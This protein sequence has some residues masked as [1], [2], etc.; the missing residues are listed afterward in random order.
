M[1]TSS[2]PGFYKLSPTERLKKVAE[3]SGLSEEEISLLSDCGA[4]DPVR[5]DI[6]IENVIGIVGIPLGVAT[7]FKINGND[8]LIPMATEESS[9][10]AAASNAAKMARLKG[11]F[12]TEST[13]PVMIGQIQLVDVPEPNAAKDKILAAKERLLETAKEQDSILVK[14][15]GGPRDLTVKILDTEQGAMLRVHLMVDVRDAMGA[16]AVNTMAEAISPILEELSGGRALLKI[17]SNLAVHRM[18]KAKAVFAKE[19]LGG[20]DVVNNILKAY[21]FA[22]NDIYRCATHNKG[23]MNGIIAAALATGQDHRAIEAGAHVYASLESYKSLTKYSKNGDGDLVGEI[24]LPMAVAT[25]GGATKVHPAFQACQKILGAKNSKEMAEVFAALGL[26][27]NLA[28]LRALS[29]EGIQ[30]GHMS[31]H[32]RN[33]AVMAG[34]KGEEIER[35]ANQM[36]S[37]SSVRMSR[38]KELIE[39]L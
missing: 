21:A 20:E 31:L 1:E 39:M 17:I 10:V 37:E 24:E 11:G 22:E 3:L 15:G 38:A 14:F 25:I 13:E 4:L 19:A 9:V 18:A 28:A 30:K 23:I 26:A 33:I 36:I 34:A 5:V 7:N 12:H 29:D 16:N 35:I 6:M 27:Q 32:A 8:Y 2:I